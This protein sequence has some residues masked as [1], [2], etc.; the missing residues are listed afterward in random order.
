M[1]LML[2][3]LLE[4]RFKLKV[5]R[6]TRELPVFVLTAAKGGIKL[7]PSTTKCGPFNQNE[8]ARPR[9]SDEAPYCND[10]VRGNGPICSGMLKTLI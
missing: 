9:G 4:D 6:E 7:Q 3:E 10:I 2:Q 5:H 8:P 1:M